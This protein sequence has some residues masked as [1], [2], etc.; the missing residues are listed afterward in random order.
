MAFQFSKLT[1]RVRQVLGGVVS[2]AP[3]TLGDIGRAYVNTYQKVAPYVPLAPKVPVA[4]PL[5]TA[6]Q[7]IQRFGQDHTTLTNLALRLEKP[8][9][10]VSSF[11]QNPYNQVNLPQVNT[12]YR[13]IDLAGNYLAKPIAEGLIN[14]PR[15]IVGGGTKLS[16]NLGRMGRGDKVGARELL[17]NA[18]QIGTGLLDANLLSFGAGA[19][20]N[21]AKNAVKTTFKEAIKEGATIGAKYGGAYGLL[22]GLKDNETTKDL[23]EYTKNVLISTGQGAVAGG[24]VGAGGS[25]LAQTAGRIWGGMISAVKRSQNVTDEQAGNMVKKFFRDEKGRFAGKK[26]DGPEP[27][28]YG[29]LRESIGLPRD[30]DYKSGAIDLSAEVFPSKKSIPLTSKQQAAKAKLPKVMVSKNPMDETY[31]PKGQ[32]L[33]QAK[34]LENEARK[35]SYKITPNSQSSN[36]FVYDL[37]RSARQSNVKNKV[38]VLDYLRTPAHVLEK[39]GLKKEGEALK[40]SYDKYQTDLNTEINRITSWQKQVPTEQ[41]AVNVFKYLDGQPAQLNDEEYKVAKEIKTYLQGWAEKL[42]LPKDKQIS[43]YIT[44][45]FERDFIQKEF[46]PDIAK[47]IADKVPG[48]VYDPFL[49]KRLG[50]LGYVE[51]VWRALDAYVKRATRKYNMDPALEKLSQASEGLDIDS[52]KYVKELGDRVNLR[53][54]QIDNL[55][56]NL[57]KSVPGIGYRF[58]PRPVTALSQKWRQMVY[59][60]ALGL[61]VGSALKNLSQGVNTYSELGEKYTAK[62]YFDLMRR[63]SRE[64]YDNGILRDD[65]IQDRQ[66]NVLK[67]FWQK[68]DSALFVF[69]NAA[70][71]INRGSAYYGAKAKALA[72]GK[73]EQEAIEYARKLV[74]KTQFKFGSVDTPLALSSDLA[75]TLAQF[76]TFTLKQAEFLGGKIKNKDIAGLIRYAL[77]TFVVMNTVGKLY[78]MKWQDIIPSLRIESPLTNMVGSGAQALSTD[79][80]KRKEGQRNLIKN[81]KLLIPAGVQLDKTI[82]GVKSSLQGYSESASG[83]VQYPIDTNPLSVAR[84]GVFGKYTLPE[85]REYYDKDRSVL[86]ENQSEL[87]KQ[88]PDKMG[89]Y[90]TIQEARDR[91]KAEEETK[92]KLMEGSIVN[93]DELMKSSSG[94]KTYTIDDQEVSGIVQNGKFIYLDPETGDAKSTTIKALEKKKLSQE[95]ELFDARYSLVSDQ[96]KRAEDYSSWVDITQSYIDYLKTYKAKADGEAEKLRIQNKIEDLQVQVDKYKGY[97]G[98]KKPKKPKKLSVKLL[99]PQKAKKINI[100][101]KAPKIPKQKKLKL[102]LKKRK[103]KISVKV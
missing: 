6:Q 103:S 66:L 51:N 46:D 14:A 10:K 11:L 101:I 77:G 29:D 84:A 81:V 49:Q 25:V 87:V 31:I 26:P 71:K 56:D 2:N 65:I 97:G 30:G 23:L 85:A 70:E 24:T 90:N 78:G 48:S 55:I 79:E 54:T 67:N 1:D 72:Q 39:I 92:K 100:K 94:A 60:G 18:G 21:I 42:G 63:G 53:P 102:T 43:H 13:G 95:R 4:R 57:L 74:E 75:K 52:W 15:N 37:E 38:N 91:N 5:Q 40:S 83:R 89:T 82:Q 36:D 32:V 12:G 19:A 27:P 22:S 8:V 80:E 59:R 61:N 50:K 73:S 68:A 69:F 47:I 93:P 98:F 16:L 28:Y 86:G 88:S 7:N 3:Q 62:G 20:K 35:A 17:A 41:S 96:L 34:S 76:Q 58:G 64:L 33:E 99:K 44:H 9:Q 45:I